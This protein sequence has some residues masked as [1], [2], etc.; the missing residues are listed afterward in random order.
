MDPTTKGS[1]KIPWAPPGTRATIFNPP[2]LQTSFSTRVLDAWCIGS[3]KDH[4]RCYKL[5]LSKTGH[6][7]IIGRAKFYPT[8]Y[9]TPKET[10]IDVTKRLARDLL[11]AVKALHKGGKEK[12]T[13]HVEALKKLT[14]I[15]KDTTGEIDETIL[16]TKN[17]TLSN[18]IAP[19]IIRNAP[20]VNAR[21]TRNNIPNILPVIAPPATQRVTK[22]P[23]NTTPQRVQTTTPPP[24]VPQI[25]SP[26]RPLNKRR[27]NQPLEMISIP[28]RIT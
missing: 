9:K 28:K 27:C 1:T 3:A 7:Q 21:T 26:S 17:H 11:S 24:R 4:Y 6:M 13:H 19:S 15:F 10:D 20:R 12:P 23:V 25:A 5:W 18:P 8:H 22:L 2:E 16:P 14:E